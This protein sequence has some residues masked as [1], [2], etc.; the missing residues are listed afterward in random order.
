MALSGIN[1]GRRG[2]AAP[3][4]IKDMAARSDLC[5]PAARDYSFVKGRGF[6]VTDGILAAEAHALPM[7]ITGQEEGA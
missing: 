5:G 3:R 2:P 7:A 4:K 1:P 6:L